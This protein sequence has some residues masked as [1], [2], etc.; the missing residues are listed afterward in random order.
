[1][2]AARM[3]AIKTALSGE[4]GVTPPQPGPDGGAPPPPGP[5]AIPPPGAAGGNEGRPN[6]Y[7][8]PPRLES[9]DGGTRSTIATSK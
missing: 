9:K 2:L 8:A 4:P 5:P 3:M 7:T 6:T 1:M